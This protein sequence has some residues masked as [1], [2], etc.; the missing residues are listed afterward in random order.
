MQPRVT[1]AGKR[2][3]PVRAPLARPPRIVH[4]EGMS[5]G[6]RWVGLLRAVNVGGR[7]LPMAALRQAAADAGCTEVTTLLASGNVVFTATGGQASVRG[8]LEQAIEAGSGLRVEVLLRTK[9]SLQKL[10]AANPFP[11][12]NPS[13]VL[14]G[15]LD[16][17]APAGLAARL[18]E[19]ANAEQ[20]RVAGSEVWLHFPDGVGR[21]K[22]FE[23]LPGVLRP[24]IVTTRNVN[25]VT[26]LVDLL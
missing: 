12:G 8:A 5:Q 11:E 22:L 4:D 17:P 13:R 9:P 1:G 3:E 25:T 26:K 24:R 14:V 7:A 6:K 16:G 19:L 15:F 18:D 20:V 10:L 2:H 21:S 23:K